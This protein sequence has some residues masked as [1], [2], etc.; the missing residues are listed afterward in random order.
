MSPMVNRPFSSSFL[1]YPLPTRQK[2]VSGRWPHMSLRYSPSSSWAMRTP[3]SSGS[4][5][6]ASMSMATL[7]RYRF[8]PMPAAA[9]M[10]VV[11]STSCIIIFASSLGVSR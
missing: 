1:A 6:L 8:V 10:P 9:T 5:C 4:T 3:S 2:S 7:H 11:C